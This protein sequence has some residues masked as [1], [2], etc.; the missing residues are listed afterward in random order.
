ME[1]KI[2]LRNEYNRTLLALGNVRATINAIKRIKMAKFNPSAQAN[3]QHLKLMEENL[4]RQS[5]ILWDRM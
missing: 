4:E 1:N 5:K 2:Q 3:L